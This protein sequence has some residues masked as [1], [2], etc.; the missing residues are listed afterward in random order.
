MKRIL[1]IVAAGVLAVASFNAAHA[2]DAAATGGAA[3]KAEAAVAA[4]SA[5]KPATQQFTLKDGTTL[6]VDDKQGAWTT[7]AAGKN[8]AATDGDKETADGKKLTVKEG[9]VVAGL[10]PAAGETKKEEAPAKP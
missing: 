8:V 6:T 5:V 4:D 9:K 1:G 7:D 2:A 10:E 3:V